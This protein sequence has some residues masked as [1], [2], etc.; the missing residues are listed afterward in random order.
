[1][2]SLNPNLS[3]KVTFEQSVQHVCIDSVVVNLMTSVGLCI[4]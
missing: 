2:I 3:H 1:M 4:T